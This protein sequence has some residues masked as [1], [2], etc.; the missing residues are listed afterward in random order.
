MNFE[1]CQKRD[2]DNELVKTNR[3]NPIKKVRRNRY[4]G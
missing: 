2:F 4:V 3:V 1:N